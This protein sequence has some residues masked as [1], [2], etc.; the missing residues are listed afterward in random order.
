[1]ID[2]LVLMTL[3]SR[4]ELIDVIKD[5]AML[6]DYIY[7]EKLQPIFRTMMDLDRLHKDDKRVVVVFWTP[8]IPLAMKTLMIDANE[9][10]IYEDKLIRLE[11]ESPV[12]AILARFE[13]EV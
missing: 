10:Y 7:V 9:A 3:R 2:K 5:L 4:G 8:T 6:G 12:E 1:M 13:L 11:G